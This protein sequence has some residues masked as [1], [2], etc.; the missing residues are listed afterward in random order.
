MSKEIKSEFPVDIKPKVEE[1]IE[2]KPKVK[3]V[4]FLSGRDRKPAICFNKTESGKTIVE[5]LEDTPST[6]KI[7]RILAGKEEALLLNP[8]GMD[9]EPPISAEEL[10]TDAMTEEPKSESK[11]KEEKQEKIKS[12]EKT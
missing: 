1:P 6:R 12:K 7:A 2:T 8:K 11:P 9:I 3:L 4:C 10:K 5:I